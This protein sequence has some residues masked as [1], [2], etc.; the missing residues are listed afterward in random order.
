MDAGWYP[1]PQRKGQLR[2]WNGEW[3]EWT[4]PVQAPPK[5][6]AWMQV[7]IVLLILLGVAFYLFLQ[8]PFG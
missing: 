4:Q 2:F 1:D 3:T 8:D 6:T 5:S 7:G